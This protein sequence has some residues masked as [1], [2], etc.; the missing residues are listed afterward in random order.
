MSLPG[1]GGPQGLSRA[2]YSKYRDILDAQVLCAV[3]L[4]HLEVQ[5]DPG[6]AVHGDVGHDGKGIPEE[7]S[8][9]GDT[10]DGHGSRHGGD[11]STQGCPPSQ[12]CHSQLCTPVSLLRLHL[13]EHAAS[14]Q[15]P[16][17]L[18][19]CPVQASGH[20]WE[21]K[22]IPLAQ[23][24]HARVTAHLC[25]K[26]VPRNC[27]SRCPPSWTL[28]PGVP[29]ALPH[30]LPAR[31]RHGPACPAGGQLPPTVQNQALLH[32]ETLLPAA[33]P[34]LHS[35]GTIPTFGSA[36]QSRAPL[37]LGAAGG[38]APPPA[39][40]QP[41]G[42][43]PPGQGTVPGAA[44]PTSL[45]S[46]TSLRAPKGLGHQPRRPSCTTPT[47]PRPGATVPRVRVPRQAH[48]TR[49]LLPQKR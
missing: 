14:G 39:T 26:D 7:H 5:Q 25:P 46:R 43:V 11:T 22:K 27:P 18:P 6:Q 36:T 48:G 3:R 23:L 31:R 37:S 49:D 29:L 21:E 24:V 12:A 9:R 38:S 40:L 4:V 20:D 42:E 45:A 17:H 19:V 47:W 32:R 33:R 15:A 13:R 34:C 41:G 35:P 44:S 1:K 8:P 30:L 16:V 28:G 2:T 10:G